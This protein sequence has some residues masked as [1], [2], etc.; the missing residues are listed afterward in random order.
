MM[1]LS[2][3]VKV[4]RD[5]YKCKYISSH[6]KICLYVECIQLISSHI[7]S[8]AGHPLLQTG[9]KVLAAFIQ[10]PNFSRDTYNY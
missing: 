8:V 10:D 5:F 9:S 6:K 4:W 3:A 2:N 7:L 1:W